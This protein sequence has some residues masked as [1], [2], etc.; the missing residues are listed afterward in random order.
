MQLRSCIQDDATTSSAHFFDAV[1]MI[2]DLAVHW[3]FPALDGIN[4]A[5]EQSLSEIGQGRWNGQFHNVFVVASHLGPG[6]VWYCSLFIY[7]VGTSCS[8]SA[9]VN[10]SIHPAPFW[11]GNHFYL[12][13]FYDSQQY[14]TIVYNSTLLLYCLLQTT[15]WR[16]NFM[17]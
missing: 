6:V 1:E 17:V 14:Q 13:W 3:G 9:L 15:S 10:G 4:K 2:D 7:C 12:I 8:K 11:R 16:W 5:F